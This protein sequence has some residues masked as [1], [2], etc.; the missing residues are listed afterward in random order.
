[1]SL[2]R[3]LDAPSKGREELYAFSSGDIPRNDVLSELV[4]RRIFAFKAMGDALVAQMRDEFERFYELTGHGALE[5]IALFFRC[6]A[7]A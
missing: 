7:V 1:M 3:R 6:S 4:H 5:P 2:R